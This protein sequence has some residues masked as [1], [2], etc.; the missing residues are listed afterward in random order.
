MTCGHRF[1]PASHPE[2]SS[3]PL[4]F[5]IL[6][7]EWWAQHKGQAHI[8]IPVLFSVTACPNAVLGSPDD[9]AIL[10]GEGLPAHREWKPAEH[11]PLPPKSRPVLC[12]WLPVSQPWTSPHH[13]LLVCCKTFLSMLMGSWISLACMQLEAQSPV[14]RVR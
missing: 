3:G 9:S 2:P 1:H 12:S 4:P 13:Q 14:S 6:P 7:R 8:L 10:P 11:P 5:S